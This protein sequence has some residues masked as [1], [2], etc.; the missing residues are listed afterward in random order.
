MM[1]VIFVALVCS[2][3]AFA[4][5]ASDTP[6]ALYDVLTSPPGSRVYEER[7]NLLMIQEQLPEDV[8]SSLQ[9]LKMV[10]SQNSKDALETIASR[11][12]PDFPEQFD[13]LSRSPVAEEER[14]GQ[15]AK[16][17][18]QAYRAAA[19]ASA[20]EVHAR[21]RRALDRFGSGKMTPEELQSEAARLAAYR[22]FGSTY[23]M[24][25]NGML[26]VAREARDEHTTE[27]AREMARRLSRVADSSEAVDARG[28]GGRKPIVTLAHAAPP[29]SRKTQWSP[30]SVIGAFFDAF[31]KG[32]VVNRDLKPPWVFLADAKS[33]LP[34]VMAKWGD[35]G[36]AD[37]EVFVVFNDAPDEGL[38]KVL[39][40]LGSVL[41]T[42]EPTAFVLHPGKQTP[43]F[44]IGQAVYAALDDK[45][46]FDFRFDTWG[47]GIV[48]K[49]DGEFLLEIDKRPRDDGRI[50]VRY[51]GRQDL[52]RL[53][54]ERGIITDQGSFPNE[55]FV[56][57]F[58]VTPD[59]AK[60]RLLPAAGD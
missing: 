6:R 48:R 60:A 23:K 7:P 4:A 41:E 14:S 49:A 3:S 51:E 35:E 33:G 46:S 30:E 12:A 50:C 5:R 45:K 58:L 55:F 16:Q 53:L 52:R 18:L 11:L 20:G 36:S 38:R 8:L 21:A 42:G 28:T 54:A 40:G 37:R 32:N 1:C 10:S 26:S 44:L 59:E 19:V 22:I 56:Q 17:F 9:E 29:S 24:M 15:F 13:S 39:F 31:P 27:H 43:H 47:I 2:A 57:P 34:Y 25:T